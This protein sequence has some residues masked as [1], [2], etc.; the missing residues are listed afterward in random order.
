MPE[1]CGILYTA[2]QL[3]HFIVGA[4]LTCIIRTSVVH[5]HDVACTYTLHTLI[6]ACATILS[7]MTEPVLEPRASDTTPRGSQIHK[8]LI[9][10]ES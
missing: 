3:H 6:V 4:M 5:S 1:E 7:W 2:V 10:V 8:G 9:T